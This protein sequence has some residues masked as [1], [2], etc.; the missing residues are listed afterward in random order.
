MRQCVDT[1]IYD[2]SIYKIKEEPEDTKGSTRVP[3][4]SKDR[5]YNGK[6]KMDKRRSTKHYTEN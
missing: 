2:I 1:T 6:E 4:K 3:Y 5:Q